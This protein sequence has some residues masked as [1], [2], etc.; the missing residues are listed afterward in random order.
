LRETPSVDVCIGLHHDRLRNC[1]NFGYNNVDN[2]N[3]VYYY[4]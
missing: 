1:N 2:Y 3:F 4:Y